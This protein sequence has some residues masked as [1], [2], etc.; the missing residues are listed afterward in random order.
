MYPES[1]NCVRGFRALLLW[2]LIFP[3]LRGQWNP[4]SRA[5]PSTTRKIIHTKGPVRSVVWWGWVPETFAGAP[6]RR[7]SR[8]RLTRYV[9]IGIADGRA[10]G[11][12]GAPMTFT[13]VQI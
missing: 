11:P 10:A 6:K 7:P 5:P 1:T 9:A 3:L 2:A 8:T 4:D 12:G 13:P